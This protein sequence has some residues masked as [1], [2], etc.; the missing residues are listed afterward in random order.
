MDPTHR[1][2]MGYFGEVRFGDVGVAST[3]DVENRAV[4][5]GVEPVGTVG[6]GPEAGCDGGFGVARWENR[7][8]G[9]EP[10]FGL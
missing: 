8:D 9:V 1:K 6:L 5:F 3:R 2:P 4:G 10:G 7:S